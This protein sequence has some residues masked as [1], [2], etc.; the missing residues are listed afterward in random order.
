MKILF[1][2]TTKYDKENRENFATFHN[3]KYGLKQFLEGILILIG[4]LYIIIFNIANLNWKFLLI[5]IPIGIFIY[6]I[7]KYVEIKKKEK[8]KQQKNKEF[9]F[10]F[11]ERYI[12]IKFKRQFERIH[13][14]QLKKIF[15]TDQN[16]FLY[17]DEK[18]SLILDKEGFSIGTSKEF[19][20]FIKRKC[21]FK[22][23]NKEN[24]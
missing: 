24:K 11:Y 15:E 5:L 21:P 10:F 14:F 1:K 2:N 9:T 17:T 8:N 19:S 23:S 12:K 13:Y 6:F 3:K 18:H 22:Y 16:F 7:N 20:E 4:I